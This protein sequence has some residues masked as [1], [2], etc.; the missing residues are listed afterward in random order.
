MAVADYV[1]APKAGRVVLIQAR[2]GFN[3]AQLHGLRSFWRRRAG[4]GYLARLVNGGH[5]D[6]LETVELQRVA[7]TLEQELRRFDIVVTSPADSLPQEA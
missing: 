4:D 6:M 7:R 5:W 1:C 3:R 2:E